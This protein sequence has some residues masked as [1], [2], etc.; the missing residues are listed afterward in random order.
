MFNFDA[1][2]SFLQFSKKNS[3]QTLVHKIKYKGSKM[4]A[5]QLGVW[6]A[7][8]VLLNISHR[9]D[10]IVP[11]PL[12]IGKRKARGFNQS[13]EISRGIALVTGH[14]VTELLRRKKGSETQTGLNRWQ[15]FENTEND[16]ELSLPALA[17][18][19]NILLV[20]DII[21][22]G[23]TI[24]GNALPLI[25]GG[26]GRITIAAIGLTQNI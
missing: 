7:S 13:Y 16:F 12:A 24:T 20:D 5:F 15:R 2:Y 1:A 22:T 9:F 18:H 21:T 6:F 26:C 25:S 11:V 4:L 10:V 17:R 3:V 8:E 23:A 14:P 19:T